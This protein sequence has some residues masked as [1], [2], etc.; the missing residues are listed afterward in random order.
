MEFTFDTQYNAK[1]MAV[2]AKA[3]RKTIRKKHSRRSHVVGWIVTVLAVLL[4]AAG[5]FTLD[6][7]TV[8]TTIAVLAILITLLFEDRIN[9]YVAKK[10]LLAGTEQAVTVFREN[11]FLSTTE[12]GKTEWNYDKILTIAEAGDFFVFIFSASHAQLYDKRSLQGGTADDFRRF[13]ETATGK[14][15]QRIN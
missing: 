5:G 12:V 1:T 9:G 6:L 2:M 3:L 11:G 15:V 10:R 14:Q 8:I 4:L 13:I 7:R